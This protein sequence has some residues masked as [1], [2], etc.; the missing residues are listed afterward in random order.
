MPD[1]QWG[2]LVVTTLDRDNGMLRYDLEEAAMLESGDCPRGE[3]SKRGFWGGRFSDLLSSQGVHFQVS[4]LEKAVGSVRS[5]SSPR[6]SSSWS[7]RT[8]PPIR[9]RSASRSAQTRARRL[10]I[11]GPNWPARS[12]MRCGPHSALESKVDVLDRDTL[13]G[14]ATS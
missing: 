14:P 5:W 10:R 3:T 6:S 12:A 8:V 1:G 2:N 11:V 9:F 13:R 4:E 7:S